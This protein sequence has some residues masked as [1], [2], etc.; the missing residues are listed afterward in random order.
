MEAE[1]IRKGLWEMVFAEVDTEGKMED[2]VKAELQKMVAKRLTKKMAEVRAEL[3]LR[4]ERD[5]LAHMH[6]RDPKDIWETLAR[7]HHA[8]GLGTRMALRR[9]LFKATKGATESMAAWIS[10]V[11]GMALDLE[12]IG[13]MVDDHMKTRFL[14][15]QLDST[16]H[17]IHLLSHLTLLLQQ[18]LLLTMLSTTCSTRTFRGGVLRRSRRKLRVLHWRV[19]D[20]RGMG[21]D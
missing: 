21:R 6:D 19:W 9:K 2:E 15:S 18:I 12:D 20:I 11:K 8:R 17:M 13:V 14:R 4:I 5:Q 1:L 7:L 10:R 16:R 3:I